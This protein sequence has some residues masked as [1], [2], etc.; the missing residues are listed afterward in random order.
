MKL[1]SEGRTETECFVNHTHVF[2][3][4]R[5]SATFSR[6]ENISEELDLVE[7]T[8]DF[9]HPDF[10]LACEIGRKMARMWTMKL[11]SDFPQKRFRVYYTQYDNPIVRF[12]MVRPEEP[13]WFSDEQLGSATDPSF[14]NAVIYDTEYLDNPV[15]KSNLTR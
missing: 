4:F 3:E 9:S 13:L 5:N 12:H 10:V 1:L 2:D 15:V 11:K 14:G 8:Y 6:R 7:E